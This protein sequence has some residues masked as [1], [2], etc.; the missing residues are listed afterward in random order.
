MSQKTISRIR[1]IKNY[2]KQYVEQVKNAVETVPVVE[3][4]IEWAEWAEKTISESDK[5]R[6]GAFDTPEIYSNLNLIEDSIKTV[7]PELSINPQVIGGTIGAANATLSEV[8]FDRMNSGVNSLG[9]NSSWVNSLNVEYYA[10]QKKQNIIDDIEKLLTNIGL[11]E[12]FIKAVD[13]YS[14]V[15][16]K[17]SSTEDAAIIMRNLLE[18]L[19]G[20]LF[21][22]VGENAGPLQS[23]KSM[24]W[25]YIGNYLAVGGEGSSQSKMLLNKKS[26]YD[27]VHKNLTYIAKNSVPNPEKLLE[28]Y[29]SKWLDFLYTTLS[30]IDPKYLNL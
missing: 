7:L 22:V 13:K 15:N 20:H 5:N 6:D 16:S 29:Y 17:I 10:L 2:Q 26:V 3:K 14:K 11:K 18:G 23:K 27:D 30:L 8:V 21:K 28:T 19:Q 4:N 12:E 25:D 9:N 24:R 1:K